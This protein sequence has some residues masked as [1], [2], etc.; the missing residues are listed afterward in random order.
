[1][2]AKKYIVYL[3]FGE[4]Q[5]EP[6]YVGAGSSED[7]AYDFQSRS[8]EWLDIYESFDKKIKVEIFPVE[9]K[10]E[11]KELEAKFIDKYKYCICNKNGGQYLGNGQLILPKLEKVMNNLSTNIKLAR[12]RRNLTISQMAERCGMSRITYS[13]IE[14]GDPSVSTAA[15]VNVFFI[16]GME[17]EIS[18]LGFEDKV[19]RKIQDVNLLS[20][21]T[22]RNNNV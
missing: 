1:M 2:K 22:K 13:K 16:L 21:R 6:F 18:N 8:K 3:H 9:S 12:L 17:N 15:L 7:R 19:G 11:A 20:G 5:K 10:K 4:D 14:S